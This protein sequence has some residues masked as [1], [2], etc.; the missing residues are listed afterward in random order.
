MVRPRNRLKELYPS[1]R[2]KEISEIL[3]RNNGDYE[4]SNIEV[5]QLSQG[6]NQGNA[7]GTGVIELLSSDHQGMGK[8][9]EVDDTVEEVNK[10][11][12][13]TTQDRLQKPSIS[14]FMERKKREE[15]EENNRNET[16]NNLTK[17]TISKT[18]TLTDTQK[19]KPPQKKAAI[20]NKKLATKKQENFLNNP[21]SMKHW[22]PPSDLL[23][24]P[25][26]GDAS[27][28]DVSL[29][30]ALQEEEYRNEAQALQEEEYRNEARVESKGE[31]G[32]SLKEP[33]R[34]V[35]PAV[36][37]ATLSSDISLND[38]YQL[39]ANGCD[40]TQYCGPSRRC[41]KPST[42][43][44]IKSNDVL[45]NDDELIEDR[46]EEKPQSSWRKKGN[47]YV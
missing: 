26:G 7:K 35:G 32:A 44:K 12:T 42:L 18:T 13:S 25:E 16:V 30:Q 20:D 5:Q 31:S 19:R 46:E 37:T 15:E 21:L 47:D 2:L 8:G 45:D 23:L 27:D 6:R 22:C 10:N 3:S 14:V 11:N 34:G 24:E 33:P 41:N 4:R 29:A 1:V 9:E 28:V 38:F 40:I 17:R 39:G 43:Y 36:S